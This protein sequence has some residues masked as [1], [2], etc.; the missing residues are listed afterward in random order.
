M[1]I[2]PAWNPRATAV[3]LAAMTG[4]SAC[5]DTAGPAAPTEE[6]FSMRSW[7]TVTVGVAD[8]DAAL[9]LWVDTFGLEVMA[10]SEG[11]DAEL[12]RLWDLEPEDIARQTIVH[13]PG[14]THG[15]IHLVRFNEPG[16]PVRQGAE[17]FDLVPKNLDI[18]ARDLPTRF[19]ELKAAGR[20]FRSETYS[21]VT[22]PNGAVFREI[23]MPSHDDI[24]V[25]L[26]EV[27]GEEHPFTPQGFAGV[28]PVITIVPDATEE[29]QFYQEILGLAML[30]DN[31]LKGPE[32]ERMVGLPAGAYLDVSVLGQES[33]HF[34]RIEIVDYQGVEGRNLF[35]NAKPKALGTL[36]VSY[37]LPNLEPLQARLAEAGIEYT[38]H[39]V[40]ETLLGSGEVISFH[41]PAGLRIEAHERR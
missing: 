40:I 34:G 7:T 19:A 1:T 18:H 11:P 4:I 15:M 28:G 12:A 32:I 5:N 6:T 21:E 16:A 20:V 38:N 29:Q 25:V 31:I 33:E 27:I 41:S 2:W 10:S 13:T 24:N 22:A 36:H 3:A 23:H 30:S 8:L 39:G 9:E 17:V 26:L 37:Q 35:P 14:E